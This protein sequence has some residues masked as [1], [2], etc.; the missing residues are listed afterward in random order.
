MIQGA[1]KRNT[2]KKRPLSDTTLA[3]LEPEDRD[4]RERDTGALYFVVQKTGKKSWQLRYK[5]E[6]GVWS[7]KGIGGYPS[8]SGAVARRKANELLEKLANGEILETR[9]QTKQ[10]QQE[11]EGQK[12]SK[13][14]NEWLDTK[15]SVWGVTTFDKAQK[16]INRHII[17]K[18][19]HRDY[20]E[21]T[22]QD[23]G[24][25]GNLNNTYK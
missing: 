20:S 19:G 21:I 25:S 6:K 2:I 8:V 3:N 15:K 1:M 24:G 4:Y 16:S 23:R 13:L 5:N 11:I 7:W 18:F 17:P 14:M 10:K 9:K 22:P 12:F